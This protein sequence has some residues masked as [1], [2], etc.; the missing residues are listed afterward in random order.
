MA[1]SVL[2]AVEALELGAV[3]EFVTELLAFGAL[4]ARFVEDSIEGVPNFGRTSFDVFNG[5]VF[6][7]EELECVE[8]LWTGFA[9]CE[10][11]WATEVVRPI[12]FPVFF[13]LS[14]SGS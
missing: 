10:N 3:S 6:G 2:L 11:S 8:Q 1:G 7:C 4:G 9:I 13:S 12:D 5:V 14:P